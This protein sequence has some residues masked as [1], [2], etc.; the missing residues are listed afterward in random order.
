M[1]GLVAF[2]GPPDRKLLYRLAQRLSHRGDVFDSFATQSSSAAVLEWEDQPKIGARQTG[3]FQCDAAK[4]DSAKDHLEGKR[5]I[6]LAGFSFNEKLHSD[7]RS[8]KQLRGSYAVCVANG[9][10]VVVARDMT[11]C[12]SLY[13]GAMTD[14]QG[15]K[16]W[17][18]A[19]EPKA[20]TS[21]LSFRKTLRPASLAQYLAFSFVPAQFTML[22]EVFEVEAGTAVE[23]SSNSDPK[24]TRVFDFESQEYSSGTNDPACQKSRDWVAETKQCIERAVAERLVESEPVVF[25][26]GGLDSS[27]IAA[28]VARQSSQPIRTFALHFGAKYTNEL[29][30][31]RQVAER[32]GSKHEEILI[33]PKAFLPNLRQMVWH[34]DEPIGDPITQ[35]NYELASKVSS[36]G[37]FVFN[38]EG[39]DPLFGGPKNIPMML[40][41]W[42]GGIDRPKNFREQAYLASYR[43][44]YEEWSRLLTP[45]FRLSISES[46]D[47]EGPLIPFFQTQRPRSFLNKL[48][49]I[50]IRLKGANLILP[51]VDRM[52]AAHG[53]TPLSPLFDDQL[54]LLSFAMPPTMKLRNGVEKVVLKEAFKGDLPRDIIER[55]KSGM[56]VPVHFWFQKDLRRYARK[57]LCKRSI[58]QTGIFEYERVKQLLDYSTEEGPGRYGLRLWMLLT[59]EIWRR[60]VI[61]GESV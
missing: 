49:A 59:F 18:V 52:L 41:H 2:T 10:G 14:S 1:S 12:Q 48:M 54:T 29:P 37:R 42:Y 17:L 20:I 32:I 38:G 22:E 46:A 53:L 31:A 11:G 15:Q 39:G 57:I 5:P 19:S 13:Y 24:V 30:F 3:I 4:F 50:N 33:R 21:E 43:R 6:A 35:P 60:I 56:R 61:E 9:E 34:L 45:D 26:S 55:P 58:K 16:R 7:F 8:W 25:L 28:E 47:L 40:A 27:L 23:L 36:L 44:A 51:K